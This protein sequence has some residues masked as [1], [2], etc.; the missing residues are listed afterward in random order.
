MVIVYIKSMPADPDTL[1]STWAAEKLWRAF[2]LSV[3]WPKW[4][5]ISAGRRGV[6]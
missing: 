3:W 6:H 2:L 1:T 5:R 4:R